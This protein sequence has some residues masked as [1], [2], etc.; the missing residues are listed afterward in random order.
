MSLDRNCACDGTSNVTVAE[1]PG[2][3]LHRA[4]ESSKK[5]NNT[6]RSSEFYNSLI[7]FPE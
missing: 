2:L 5:N 4:Q 6:R 3:L 7:I 1:E